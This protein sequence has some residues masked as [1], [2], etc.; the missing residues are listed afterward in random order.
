MARREARWVDPIAD[1][2]EPEDYR[3]R[4]ASSSKMRRR[5]ADKMIRRHSDKANANANEKGTD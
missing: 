2:P 4:P 5:P 3:K 1:D